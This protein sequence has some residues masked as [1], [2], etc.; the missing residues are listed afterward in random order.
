MSVGTPRKKTGRGYER[1]LNADVLQP[2]VSSFELPLRAEKKSP[3][4]IRTYVEA[5]QWMA[6]EYPIPGGITD[7][8]GV[9]AGHVNEW[10]IWLLGQYSDCY[11]NN[12]FRAWRGHGRAAPSSRTASAS[13]GTFQ[14]RG[15]LPGSRGPAE[16]NGWSNP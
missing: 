4:T 7:W 15:T 13:A 6:A 12:Q 2:M 11:A 5:A 8:A 14:I 3:K 10:T 1:N 9:H 16:L